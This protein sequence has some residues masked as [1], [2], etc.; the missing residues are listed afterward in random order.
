MGLL[1]KG[2][3]RVK[4][5]RLRTGCVKTLQVTSPRRWQE[6]MVPESLKSGLGRALEGILLA[7]E[8][9]L[10]DCIGLPSHSGIPV[11]QS[12]GYT[13]A[14]RAERRK[15]GSAHLSFRCDL[16]LCKHEPAGPAEQVQLSGRELGS[17]RLT[18][19]QQTR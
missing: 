11:L 18:H 5:L 17:A 4:P 15:I 12:I 19:H 13:Q 1:D 8:Y 9:V 7:E 10:D 3:S 14:S 6:L 16:T 2:K